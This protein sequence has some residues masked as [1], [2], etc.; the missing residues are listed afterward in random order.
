MVHETV[1]AVCAA[2][3]WK[4]PQADAGG[5]YAFSLEGADGLAF[6]LSSPD[7]DRLLAHS[8]LLAP[9]EGRN[10]DDE[11]PAFVLG[12]TSARFSRLRA[13]PALDLA[14]GALELY[15]FAEMKEKDVEKLKSFMESF[16]N[17]LAFWKA[18]LRLTA[19]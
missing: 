16:L 5:R 11:I 3:G 13:V 12:V 2:A 4:I 8:I 7:G 14:S 15:S 10:I 9:E 18:Q 1:A 17:D 6:T 19:A